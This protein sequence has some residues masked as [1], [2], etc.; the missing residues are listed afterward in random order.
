M[1]ELLRPIIARAQSG[2]RE[3]LNTLAGC[4]DRFLRMFSG[5]LPRQIRR[6]SGSTIDFVMEGLAVAFAELASFEY[7]SDEQFY[8]WVS[9]T[10]RSRMIDAWRREA[11]KRRGGRPIS[12]SE[13]GVDAVSC[14]PDAASAAAGGELRE[15][16]ARAILDLHVEQPL[17]MEV[18]VLRY[19]EDES[20]EMV[21]SLLGLSSV[22]RART[23]FAAGLDKLRPRLGALASGEDAA[24]ALGR[25]D[26]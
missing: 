18:V 8:A 15:A 22:K 10:I 14:E 12:L 1:P 26:P 21:R 9:R 4:A 17:E 13:E 25:T 20:W 24:H 19:F 6:T 7:R 16:V 11:T 2:D 5:S 23:L 3:A